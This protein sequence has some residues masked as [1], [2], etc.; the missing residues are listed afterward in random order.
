[1]RTYTIIHSLD[2]KHI[3]GF[4]PK[5]NQTKPNKETQHIPTNQHQHHVLFQGV[6]RVPK[7]VDKWC[8]STPN[9]LSLAMLSKVF[10]FSAR[11]CH[12]TW[13]SE[14]SETEGADRPGSG[15]VQASTVGCFVGAVLYTIPYHNWWNYLN[16]CILQLKH[17]KTMLKPINFL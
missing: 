7:Q 1:M 14:S 9:C 4:V 3:H 13:P 10:C 16:Y 6:S 2:F 17:L 12:F 11:P 8:L 5:I 15:L